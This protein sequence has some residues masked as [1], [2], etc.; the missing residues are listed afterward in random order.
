MLK[1]NLK[2]ARAVQNKNFFA[3]LMLI[4]VIICLIPI[5]LYACYTVPLADDFCM[6]GC[7]YQAWLETGSI[8]QVIVAAGKQSAYQYT[9]WSGEYICMFLQAMPIGLG[10]YRL[11][12]LSSWL[13]MSIFVFAVY[14]AGKVFFIDYL[15]T[16]TSNGFIAASIVLLYMITFIPEIYDAFYWY[17]SVVSYTLSFA[18]KLLLI[19]GIF[20]CLFISEKSCK[21]KS[22]ILIIFAFLSAGFECSFS[23]TSFFMVITAFLMVSF[24][25]KKKNKLAIM[26]WIATTVGWGVAMLAPGNMVRQNNNYGGTT[27]IVSA[28]WE[29]LHR[30]MDG[31][32][33]N[34]DMVL[35]LVTLLVLPII[36]KVVKESKCEFR[37]PGL[38]SLYSIAIYASSYAPWVF[39]RGVEAPNPYGGDSGYIRNVFWMTFVLLWFVN[40]TYWTGWLIKVFSIKSV[41]R[42]SEKKTK[43]KIA[44]YGILLFLVLFWS[45]KLEH[46]MEYTSP[47]LLWHIANGNA[48]TYYSA[49]EEREEI[50]L[51]NSNELIVVPK[52]EMPIPTRGAGDISCDETHWVNEGVKAYYRLKCGVKTEE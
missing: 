2:K 27:G 43:T 12:F 22:A 50:L 21:I 9:T 14:Y 6:A 44:Y 29:S 38:L 40:I 42:G 1:C 18:V 39:S 35:I 47:R 32:S 13:I 51:R 3:Y 17:T 37:L 5:Y 25:T 7:S 46:I 52:I 23:Q 49:M 26:L 4:I 24:Y 10:D 15:K 19:T 20:K 31:I 48:A 16:S 45:L 36:Y 41:D 30:G 11:Y 8:W 34:L 33:D 28:I